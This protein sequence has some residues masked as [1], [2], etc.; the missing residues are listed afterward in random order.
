MRILG[1]EFRNRLL[2]SPKGTP[3]RPTTSLVRKA[4]FDIC[5]AYIPEARVL[6]LFA[7]SGA[8]GIEALSRGA[9][10][11]TFIERDRN[12]LR[13]LQENLEM[14]QL[15]KRSTLIAG[16][17]FTYLK[18]LKSCYDLIL[19]DPPYAHDVHSTLLKAIDQ[20]QLL[21]SEGYL[22]LETGYPIDFPQT[23]ETLQLIESRRYG[24]T[25]LHL[26]TS[27]KK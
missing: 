14:L 16:N 2:K 4:V 11:A 6:D 25:V 9:A 23:L 27:S 7:G 22:F 13:C 5:Q 24:K 19:A 3:T 18:R 20:L 15:Q 8:L 1:G 21:A 10:H 12:A 17:V 26:W